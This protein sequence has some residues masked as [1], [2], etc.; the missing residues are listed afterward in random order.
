M[1]NDNL[2]RFLICSASSGHKHAVDEMLASPA[3]Q[4]KVAD[5]KVARDVAVLNGFFRMIDTDEA[6]AYYGPEEV[7]R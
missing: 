5:V 4:G 7:K 2:D 6:R 3:L 1:I